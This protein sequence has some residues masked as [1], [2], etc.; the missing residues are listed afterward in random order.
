MMTL[1]AKLQEAKVK[2]S[3]HLIVLSGLCARPWVAGESPLRWLNTTM[4]PLALV[5][6][7]L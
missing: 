3:L 5:D 7:T 4:L 6:L 2:L 1:I